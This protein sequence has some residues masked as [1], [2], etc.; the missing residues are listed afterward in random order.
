[1][2]KEEFVIRVKEFGSLLENGVKEDGYERKADAI[3]F[4]NVM[5]NMDPR[6][7]FKRALTIKETRKIMHQH[8][9]F[10]KKLM[11]DEPL[12]REIYED[13]KY[14]YNKDGEVVAEMSLEDNLE[15]VKYIKE[16]ELPC[17]HFTFLA[18]IRRKA[19]EKYYA[20]E[21]S[22]KLVK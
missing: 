8:N 20:K 2:D 15:A 11:E 5:E 3:D 19:K 22:K 18:Q 9:I 10:M 21:K 4:Y 7:C 6:R 12:R 16:K 1:M 13:I 17:T 14:S